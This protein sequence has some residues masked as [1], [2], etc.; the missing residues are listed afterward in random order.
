MYCIYPTRLI[1][2][3]ILMLN[4]LTVTLTMEIHG[5]NVF[6]VLYELWSCLNPLFEVV[7]MS[8]WGSFQFYKSVQISL[9]AWH[10]F[11]QDEPRMPKMLSKDIK[12]IVHTK[13]KITLIRLIS[14]QYKWMETSQGPKQVKMS[15]INVVHLTAFYR[16]SQSCYRFEVFPQK[17]SKCA[18]F[19][20]NVN[21]NY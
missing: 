7:R 19:D 6:N 2:A 4:V 10:F 1:T 13:M 16:F 9:L 20:V 17:L 5:T 8:S 3:V 21:D 15:T 14:I 18:S 12:V 11:H